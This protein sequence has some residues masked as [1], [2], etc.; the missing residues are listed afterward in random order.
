MSLSIF[1]K[2]FFFY[3]N[4]PIHRRNDLIFYLE[5]KKKLNK[6]KKIL[7]KIKSNII[8]ERPIKKLIVVIVLGFTFNIKKIGIK[9][10]ANLL[11]K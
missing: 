5:H 9:K 6:K 1:Q 4:E 8:Q 10:F 2:K 11:I 3:K 7:S